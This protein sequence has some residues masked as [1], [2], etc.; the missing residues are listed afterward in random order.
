MALVTDN[1]KKNI[2]ERP[3]RIERGYM[4]FEVGMAAAAIAVVV[5]I[6]SDLRESPAESAVYQV[7][8]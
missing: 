7:V 4:Y 1:F 6:E 5:I 8:I 2:V 3:C